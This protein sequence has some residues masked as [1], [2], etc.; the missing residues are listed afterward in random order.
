MKQIRN[1]QSA[2]ES[3]FDSNLFIDGPVK[4]GLVN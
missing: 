4:E 2:G 3:Q 1:S